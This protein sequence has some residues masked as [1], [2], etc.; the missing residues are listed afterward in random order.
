M[1]REEDDEEK[2]YGKEREKYMTMSSY[3]HYIGGDEKK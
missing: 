2:E 3:V 1:S